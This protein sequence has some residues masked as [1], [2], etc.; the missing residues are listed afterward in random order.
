M[1][2][3]VNHIYI[4]TT[5]VSQNKNNIVTSYLNWRGLKGIISSV[6]SSFLPV[7]H[8]KFVYDWEFGLFKQNV[9]VEKATSL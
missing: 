1:Y 2:R 5:V 6:I 8:T 3:I 9:R 4:L 7:G